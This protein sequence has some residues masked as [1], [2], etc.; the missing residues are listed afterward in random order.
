MTKIFFNGKNRYKGG[1]MIYRTIFGG[2]GWGI[3]PILMSLFVMWV[4]Y[5]VYIFVLKF[6]P[7]YIKKRVFIKN[8]ILAKILSN[9]LLYLGLAGVFAIGYSCGK[10]LYTEDFNYLLLIGFGALILSFARI[11]FDDVE[12]NFMI[13]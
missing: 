7:K 12:K 9:I 2:E 10:W 5:Y 13:E 4:F 8:K 1:V 3:A 11:F 6:A